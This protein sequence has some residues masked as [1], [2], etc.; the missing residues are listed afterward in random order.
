MMLPA[1][2]AAA[3]MVAGQPVPVDAALLAGLQPVQVEATIHGEKLVCTGPRLRDL[4]GR[5]GLP[6]G[7]KLGGP[8]LANAL[9]LRARDG[10]AVLFSLAEIDATLGNSNAIVATACNGQPLDSKVGPY[11]LIVPGEQRPAR[12]MRQL[13]TIELVIPPNPPK[14]VHNH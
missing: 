10:Y 9:L 1:L 14:E 5:L 7:E 12:A 11:R 4:A 8:M 3:A 2:F 6:Q 13:D